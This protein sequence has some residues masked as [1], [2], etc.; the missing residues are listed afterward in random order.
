MKGG[1]CILLVLWVF[2]VSAQTGLNKNPDSFLSAIHQVYSFSG[3]VAVSKNNKIIY[4]RSFRLNDN[5]AGD[6][7]SR[8]RA[9]YLSDISMEFTAA[10]I[11]ELADKKQI[12]LSDS[13]GKFF[14]GL[15]R[16]KVTLSEMLNHSSGLPGYF[17]PV[18]EIRKQKEIFSNNDLLKI[19]EDSGLPVVFP[20]GTM[21]QPEYAN[22]MLLALVIEKVSGKNFR[23]FLQERIF[24]P[25][26]M[27]NTF[28]CGNGIDSARSRLISPGYYF[29]V[30]QQKFIPAENSHGGEFH[31]LSA[32]YGDGNYCST[33]EDMLQWVNNWSV[34]LWKLSES[35]KAMM[36]VSF[37]V[38]DTSV[39]NWMGYGVIRT[40]RAMG[41]AL[42][43]DGEYPGHFTT[44]LHFPESKIT[45]IVFS[46]NQYQS[47]SLADAVAQLIVGRPVQF[48]ELEISVPGD[49]TG[50]ASYAGVYQIPEENDFRV[51]TE[52]GK[53]FR[54]RGSESPIEL[55]PQGGGRFFYADKSGRSLHFINDHGK[56]T[57]ILNRS[58]IQARLRKSN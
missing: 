58:G 35:K 8:R 2:A 23:D 9:F 50:Y 41:V 55:K 31:F 10:G 1:L 33:A 3:D 52:E 18:Y 12:S 42:M 4:Q 43:R 28:W 30:G 37:S 27:Y 7:S 26:K 51:F 29:D 34:K 15:S 46:D 38:T 11:I 21:A 6:S 17:D 40:R 47:W 57:A 56:F 22:Y 16:Y 19:L 20:S 36:P 45:V 25:A 24:I 14:P 54:V 32:I 48:P 44:Y 49:T 39:K 13:I 53:L 5:K